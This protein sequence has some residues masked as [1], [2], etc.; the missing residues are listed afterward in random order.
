MAISSS[1]QQNY[2]QRFQGNK[3][4]SDPICQMDSHFVVCLFNFIFNF[5]SQELML[6]YIIYPAGLSDTELGS[7]D[8]LSKLK[9]QVTKRVCL[10]SEQNT[11]TRE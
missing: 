3:V 4:E 7:P 5:P 1:S 9:V 11:S 10:F 6:C 2:G 8:C